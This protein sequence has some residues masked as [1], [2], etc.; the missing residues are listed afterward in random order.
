MTS[1]RQIEANR[2]NA[3]LST[4]PVTEEGKRPS[5]QNAL[6]HGLTAETVIDALEDAIT[7]RSKWPWQPTTTRNRPSSANWSSDWRACC[8]G[9]VARAPLRLG[10]SGSRP[11]ICCSSG[12]SDR[13]IESARRS[14]TPRT[15]PSRPKRPCCRMTMSP[16]AALLILLLHRPQSLRVHLTISHTPL[17]ACPTC[18][19]IRLT[20][21]VAMRPRFGARPARSCSRCSAS[22]AASHGRGLG[23]GRLATDFRRKAS[24]LICFRSVRTTTRRSPSLSNARARPPC[25]RMPLKFERCRVRKFCGLY[26]FDPP[27]RERILLARSI[28]ACGRL[29]LEVRRGQISMPGSVV[30]ASWPTPADRR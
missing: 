28:S 15:D 19:P 2:R 12:D 11:S 13:P 18:R 1:F 20:G 29:R 7:R 6:R 26:F 23:Y 8:G 21:S 24:H 16:G 5:R 10:C 4:G 22:T 17:S 14:S 3:R 25:P 30:M 9:C 27:P